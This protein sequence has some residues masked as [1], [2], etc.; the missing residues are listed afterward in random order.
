MF[1]VSTQQRTV[2]S[3]IRIL[4]CDDQSLFREGVKAALSSQAGFE[5]VGEAAD[6]REGIELAALLEPSVI[7]MDVAV[8]VLKGFEATQRIRKLQPSAKILMF[9]VQDDDDVVVRCLDAGAL[10]YLLKG[11]SI[12]ELVEAIRQVNRGRYYVSPR[13]RTPAVNQALRFPGES[14][15]GYDLLSG[16]EREVLVLLAEGVMVKDVAQRLDVSVKTVEAHKYNLM[17][18][19][20]LH[21]RGEIIRYAIRRHLVEV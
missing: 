9:S 10:G 3:P 2:S 16:R 13:L 12:E 19:L 14:K 4:I 1:S 18:K 5:I 8:P 15:T 21:G 20:N 6:G 11:S 17:R 7:L